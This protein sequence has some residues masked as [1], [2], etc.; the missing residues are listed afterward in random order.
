MSSELSGVKTVPNIQESN[1]L[2]AECGVCNTVFTKKDHHGDCDSWICPNCARCSCDVSA[3]RLPDFLLMSSGRSGTTTVYA[4]LLE[5]PEIWVRQEKRPEPNFFL[6][7]ENYARG[8]ASYAQMFSDTE[9]LVVGEAS[10]S[11]LYHPVAAPRIARD[12]PDV[13]LFVMLRNPIERAWSNYWHTRKHTL[14]PLSFED[15]IE[16]EPQR[17]ASPE[18]PYWDE[19]RPHAYLDRGRYAR[20]LERFRSYEERGQLF[21]GILDDL[22]RAPGDF[23]AEAFRFLGVDSAFR[24]PSL[25]KRFNASAPVG[26]GMHEAVRKSLI[27][28][29]ED[30]IDAVEKWLQRDLSSWRK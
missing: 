5:H 3:M 17:L 20:Q 4:W 15:A 10:S 12:L 6:K 9:G 29:F 18:S 13:K 11:Y 25:E 19:V 8:L 1:G 14:E 23:A 21:V 26:G 24:P 7:S 28:L 2:R 16:A 30:E 27:D 22:V